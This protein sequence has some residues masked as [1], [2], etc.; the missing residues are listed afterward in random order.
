MSISGAMS[1]AVTGLVA[2]SASI[3]HISENIANASTVGYKRSFA[4][5]VTQT[6]P[7]G[8]SVSGVK[9]TSGSEISAAGMINATG[10]AFDIA[11][12]GSGFI[13]VSKNPNDTLASNYFLTRAG[14]FRQ[15]ENGNLVN[16]AGYYLA[17][18]PLNDD[19]GTGAIDRGAFNGLK[20]V[21]VGESTLAAEATS[22]ARVTGNLPAQETGLTTPGAPFLSSMEFYTR[23]GGRENINLSWQPTEDRNTWDLTLS[24][25]SGAVHGTVRV[26]F[27]NDATSPGAPESYSM[28]P[29]QP[30]GATG[31]LAVDPATG[32]V[33]I[34]TKV[35][36]E[37]IAIELSLG[38]PGSY[39]G[40]QQMVGD[41]T[42]QK[43]TVNGSP[44]TALARSEIDETG[45]V[46][47]VYNDGRR[48]ALYELPI[49]QVTNPDA[50]SAVEG[51]AYMLTLEAGDLQLGRAGSGKFGTVVSGALEASTV[52]IATELTDLIRIQR[53]YSTNAKVITASDEMLQEINNIKR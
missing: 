41:F 7:G 3:A 21:N 53:M 31:N 43:F 50:L 23:L 10:N 20:T 19:G 29:N 28:A 6:V 25:S 13:V 45:V 26:S 39:D 11:I 34:T 49:A 16:A 38:T 5:M 42:P 14:A 47:G 48:R 15:D 36:G 12:S 52:E 18:Y 35:V 17:A 37:T 51:N 33:T 1:T 27:S 2:N 24:D 8:N 40:I 9:A 32:I 44:Q 22:Q 30:A 46:W 4:E